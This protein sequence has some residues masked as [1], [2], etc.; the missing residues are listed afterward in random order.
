MT[1]VLEAYMPPVAH[2]SNREQPQ[3]W[4]RVQGGARWRDILRITLPEGYVP[5]VMTNH[6][7]ISVGGLLSVGGFG[8]RT[9][10]HGLVCDNVLAL[11]V[12]DGRGELLRC[13]PTNE[14]AD[15]MAAVL[16]GLGQFGL[17]ASA[18]IPL[19][20]VSIQGTTQFHC[21]YGCWYGVKCCFVACSMLIEI[22]TC[23]AVN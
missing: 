5:N 19:H 10:W 3:A 15:V 13:T 7:G 4:V 14:H 9:P 2:D 17:I 1:S 20:A 11:D 6:F 12:V 16:G 18:T 21:Y 23:G 8:S 22:T